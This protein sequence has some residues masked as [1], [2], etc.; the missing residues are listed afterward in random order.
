MKAQGAIREV[1]FLL[2]FV[3]LAPLAMNAQE[4]KEV[5][6]ATK[7]DFEGTWVGYGASGNYFYKLALTNGLNGEAVLVSQYDKT[8]RR[9]RV[10][11]RLI[12][13]RKWAVALVLIPENEGTQILLDGHLLTKALELTA[14]GTDWEYGVCLWR[15]DVLKENIRL[16]ATAAKG[17]RL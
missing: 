15:E 11:Q 16:A 2:L 9:Y 1:R 12:D 7:Q 4:A 17:S 3:L 6:P 10:E 13:F 8:C 5:R 14:R